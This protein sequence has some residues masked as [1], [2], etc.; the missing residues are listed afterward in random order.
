MCSGVRKYM[1][2]C[3]RD[4]EGQCLCVF[5]S[6]RVRWRVCHVLMYTVMHTDRVMGSPDVKLHAARLPQE[7]Y[8]KSSPLLPTFKPSFGSASLPTVLGMVLLCPK[9][10]F[11]PHRRM[12]AAH[13]A[14]ASLVHTHEHHQKRN[15]TKCPPAPTCA[16][17]SP[18]RGL[19]IIPE[20]SFV[21]YFSD[22]AFPRSPRCHTPRVAVEPPLLPSAPGLSQGEGC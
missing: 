7:D 4:R 5:V 22:S 15:A 13:T 20:G 10:D 1:C 17:R 18:S 19:S 8:S 14:D 9:S 21:D 2:T 11:D 6:T 3:V 12:L 16:L